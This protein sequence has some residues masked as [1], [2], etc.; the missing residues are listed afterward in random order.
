[1]HDRERMASHQRSKL[2]VVKSVCTVWAIIRLNLQLDPFQLKSKSICN[3][4]G[5]RDVILGGREPCCGAYLHRIPRSGG[6]VIV[7]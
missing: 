4:I 3:S 2:Q 1:M 7:V 5:R 6:S